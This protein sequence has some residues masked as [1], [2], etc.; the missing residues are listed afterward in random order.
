METEEVF[1]D[2]LNLSPA[3]VSN[4]ERTVEISS[5]QQTSGFSSRN[6]LINLIVIKGKLDYVGSVISLNTTDCL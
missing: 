4:R 6:R 2:S 3:S 1:C 5:E